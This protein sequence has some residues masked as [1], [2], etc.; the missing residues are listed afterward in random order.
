[1]SVINHRDGAAPLGNQEGGV[2]GPAPQG[3]HPT[4]L[5]VASVPSGPASPPRDGQISA[6]GKGGHSRK[7]R[8]ASSTPGETDLR[9]AWPQLAFDPERCGLVPS[10][11]GKCWPRYVVVEAFNPDEPLSKL[12]PWAL[13]K[14]F[15]GI[16]ASIKNVKRLGKTGAYLIECPDEKTSKQ[17]LVRNATM[18]IDRKIKVTPHRTMNTCRGV[19]TVNMVDIH[20]H[21]EEGLRDQGVTNVHR[22]SRSGNPTNTYFLTFGTPTP[23]EFIKIPFMARIPVRSYVQ[24][25]LQCFNCWRFGHPQ[26]KCQANQVCRHCGSKAHEGACP[27]PTVCCN[28]KGSHSPTD[29]TCPSY[30]KEVKIQKI[31]SEQRISFAE[32]RKLVEAA[33][34]NGQ[35]YAAVTAS[36][37]G[38]QGSS[39]QQVQPSN[40]PVAVSKPLKPQGVQ[41]GVDLPDALRFEALALAKGLLEELR[42]KGGK[43]PTTKDASA[44]FA[45]EA[46]SKKTKK[47]TKSATAAAKAVKQTFRSETS[48]VKA[49]KRA[50]RSAK[51]EEQV[52]KP[53]KKPSQA[54]PG[55]SSAPKTAEVEQAERPAPPKETPASAPQAAAGRPSGAGNTTTPTSRKGNDTGFALKRPTLSFGE[56]VV[57]Q[58]SGGVT[59]VDSKERKKQ[60]VTPAPA[61]QAAAGNQSM[62][63][64]TPHSPMEVAHTP[65]PAHQAAGGRAP[66]T[67]PSGRGAL[68]SLGAKI[69]EMFGAKPKEKKKWRSASNLMGNRSL[70][71]LDRE[72][73]LR[74]SNSYDDPFGSLSGDRPLPKPPLYPHERASEENRTEWG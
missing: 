59:F 16:S 51:P 44:Q 27:T 65:A 10:Q 12:S 22:V 15:S 42:A 66:S 29:K 48:A 62:P 61:L 55:G 25:P 17:L 26:S 58:N 4:L 37:T 68:S 63:S 33:A 60:G 7:K 72:E 23:P 24:K 40:A 73:P 35:S 19:I 70:N 50:E 6:T 5:S 54:K 13:Q 20:E 52:P 69:G 47:Q 8:R 53:A 39:K 43:T 32:A 1:M 49:A 34:P 41:F 64:S 46:N 45:A 2:P 31:R 14:G 36:T 21:L 30:L 11:S 9:E 57:V 3:T 74:L 67:S 18:F 56:G 71:L 28:C 38:Q